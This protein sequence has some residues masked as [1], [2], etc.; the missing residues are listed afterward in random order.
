MVSTLFM[1][2]IHLGYYDSLFENNW[3]TTTLPSNTSEDNPT[4]CIID[5]LDDN[6]FSV[7]II[8]L[9][10]QGFPRCNTK[11][12]SSIVYKHT[13]FFPKRFPSLVLRKNA[14]RLQTV[15]FRE[16]YIQKDNQG[17]GQG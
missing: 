17:K 2:N 14:I 3:L 7:S 1:V 15:Q 10:M 6:H 5:K 16:Y 8:I 11:F 9:M 12:K 13:L 4:T